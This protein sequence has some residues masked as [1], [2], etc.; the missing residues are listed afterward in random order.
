[1]RVEVLESAQ[2]DKSWVDWRALDFVSFTT[3]TP[4]I[5]LESKEAKSAGETTLRRL[6]DDSLVAAGKA[7]D[8]ETY[9]IVAD[10][11]LLGISAVRLEAL[12]DP[13]LPGL[14]PG[15]AGDGSFTL[16]DFR[17]SAAPRGK[18]ELSQPVTLSAAVADFSNPEAPV[19]GAIDSNPHTGWKTS[20]EPGRNH[21]AVFTAQQDVGFAGGTTLT[22]TLDQRAGPA[23]SLGHFRLSVTNV[24]RPVRAERPGK[25]VPAGWV[26]KAL[27][28]FEDQP[29]VVAQ[30][31]EGVGQ[32]A[33]EFEDRFSGA[34]AIRVVGDRSAAAMPRL[35]VKI[36]QNPAAGEYRFLQFAWKKVEGQAI[37][38]ELNHDGV[39]GPAVNA[40]FRYHA[41]P[42]P[43]PRGGSLLV[44]GAL[45]AR[46]TLVTRDLFQDFGEFTFSGL[47]LAMVDGQYALFDRILLARNLVDFPTDK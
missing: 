32:S 28:V 26:G 12:A 38:L 18:P 44:D 29:E 43:E 42:G 4:W 10:T 46:W 23:Q 37:C 27:A 9:T 7:I 14:G 11:D 30:L 5:P 8:A 20:A 25:V 31:K 6:A 47:G 21:L 45:P 35:G 22:V 41:G 19:A 39:W 33:L 3:A 36:R 17:V 34:M 16:S 2:S 15:R 24:A 1:V 40:K 13:L